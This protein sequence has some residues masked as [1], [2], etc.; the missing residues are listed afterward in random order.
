MVRVV[1]LT[2]FASAS[3]RRS[4]SIVP[5]HFVSP[6]YINRYRHYQAVFDQVHNKVISDF[7]ALRQAGARWRGSNPRQKSPYKSQ[8]GLTSHCA[9]N[10]PNIS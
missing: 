6:D 8:G 9:T 5:K 3:L 4:L 1:K 2:N 7:K 10:A